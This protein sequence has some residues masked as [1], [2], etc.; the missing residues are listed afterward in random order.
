MDGNKEGYATSHF[1]Y[2]DNN[3]QSGDFKLPMILD[4]PSL[5]KYKFLPIINPFGHHV[6]H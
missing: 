5:Y 6:F 4:P 3:R 1:V 2:N